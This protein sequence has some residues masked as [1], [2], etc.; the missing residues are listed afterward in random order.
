MLDFIL[1]RPRSAAM[2]WRVQIAKEFE[3]GFFALQQEIQDTILTLTRL[4]RPS[5]PLGAP[6]KPPSLGLRA[7]GSWIPKVRLE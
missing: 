7:R 4:P 6:N 2:S 3:P 5:F 1:W